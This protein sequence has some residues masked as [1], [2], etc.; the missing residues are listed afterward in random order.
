MSKFSNITAEGTALNEYK[1]AVNSSDENPDYL[2]NKLNAGSDD[3]S[4]VAENV[5]GVLKV[6][7]NVNSPTTTYSAL[8]DT[9]TSGVANGDLPIYNSTTSKWEVGTPTKTTSVAKIISDTTISNMSD[10]FKV[11][12]STASTVANAL[13]VTL[14]DPASHDNEKVKFIFEEVQDYTSET[15]TESMQYVKLETAAGSF[16]DEFQAYVSEMVMTTNKES[17][18]FVSNGTNWLLTQRLK[19]RSARYISI[20]SATTSVSVNIRNETDLFIDIAEP[21]T[22]EVT[23][24][25]TYSGSV[26]PTGYYHSIF[27]DTEVVSSSKSIVLVVEGGPAGT[28]TNNAAGDYILKYG[29]YS[30]RYG[31]A[32]ANWKT[33]LTRIV[34]SRGT[35]ITGF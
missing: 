33:D 8:T 24:T 16:Q 30:M 4:F 9:D 3:I 2:I 11:E 5:G 6:T 32:E 25:F 12:P 26:L 18:E 17:L 22:A 19:P 27:A 29:I 10:I 7:V 13:T 15:A 31:A 21:D 23:V 35:N 28:I 1:V 14:P 20:P 34:N